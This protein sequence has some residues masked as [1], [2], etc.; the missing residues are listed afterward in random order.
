MLVDGSRVYDKVFVLLDVEKKWTS[1]TCSCSVLM[2]PTGIGAKT[3]AQNVCF[4]GP[5]LSNAG[6]LLVHAL[7]DHSSVASSSL[8]GISGKRNDMG[9]SRLHRCEEVI[10]LT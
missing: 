9:L 5:C 4:P 6:L 3:L 7:R 8:P 10:V 1:T 2:M